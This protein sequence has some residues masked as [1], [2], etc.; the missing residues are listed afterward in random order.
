[1]V[2]HSAKWREIGTHLAIGFRPSELEEIQARPALYT[3]APKSLL[4][5]MLADWLQW[6]L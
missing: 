6:A 3:D 5:A 1:M 2:E 4:N